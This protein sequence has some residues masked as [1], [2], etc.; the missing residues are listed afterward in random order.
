MKSNIFWDILNAWK[1]QEPPEKG[2]DLLG[3]LLG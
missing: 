2:L 3:N 1:N